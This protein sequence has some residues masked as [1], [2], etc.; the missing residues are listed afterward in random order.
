MSAAP[1]VGGSAARSP[2]IGPRMLDALNVLA[3][4]GPVVG[5]WNLARRVGPHGSNAYGDRIV[6]RCIRAGLIDFVLDERGVYTLT[7]S[8]A[9]RGA[10]T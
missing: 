8:D 3:Y 9:G 1:R 6:M 7:L 4:S 10:L 2:R 5:K